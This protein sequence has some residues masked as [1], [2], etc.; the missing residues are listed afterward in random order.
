MKN[1]AKC[2]LCSSIIESFHATDYV[3]CKCGEIFLYGGDAMKCGAH[4]WENLLRI[5]E[6]GN[7]IIPKI[8]EAGCNNPSNKTD[9]QD[10]ASAT[11]DAINENHIPNRKELLDMLSEMI[12]NIENLPQHVM[13]N[14]ITHY[15]FCSLLILI[16]A[17]FRTVSCKDDI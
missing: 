9:H 2:K 10:Q 11:D 14:P 17:L 15:D 16:S 4:N 7:E 3:L 6:N 1:R 8:L 13:S 5:D 12:K